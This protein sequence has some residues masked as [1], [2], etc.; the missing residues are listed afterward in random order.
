M[1][2][3]MSILL[4]VVLALT[5]LGSVAM[6]EAADVTGT[7]YL[8]DMVQQGILINPS[9]LG[10]EITMELY[11]DGTA[12]V[13]LNSDD[14]LTGTW[15]LNGDIVTITA[16]DEPQD[17][18]FA[19]GVL[20]VNDDGVIMTFGLEKTVFEAPVVAAVRTDATIE[21]F[22]GE[23]VGTLAEMMGMQVPLETIGMGM[24]VTIDG[25]N[26][27]LVQTQSGVDQTFATTGTLAEGVLTLTA[28]AEDGSDLPVMDLLLHEDGTVSYSQAID[29]ENTVT[30][31][32]EQ[33]IAE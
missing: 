4:T 27:T 23:W 19:E 21:D 10:Y 6:A 25:E 2:K 24:V 15:V 3:W 5:M 32:F 8:N 13:S 29:A 26:A 22:N 11:E 20:T 1:K 7:W 12:M 9:T 28:K 17:F 18:T 30:I 33:N 16:N 31:F 14:Q